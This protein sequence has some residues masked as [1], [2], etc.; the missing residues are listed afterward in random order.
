M[1]K[2]PSERM[3]GESDWRQHINSKVSFLSFFNP[4]SQPV[5]SFLFTIGAGNPKVLVL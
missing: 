4:A 2:K 5:F 1:E 3:T